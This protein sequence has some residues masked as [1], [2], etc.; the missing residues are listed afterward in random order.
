MKSATCKREGLD[1]L[2]DFAISARGS[3]LLLK[4]ISR[5][6]GTPVWRARK[7][8]EAREIIALAEMAPSGR[9]SIE[10]IDLSEELR[11]VCTLGVPTPRRG[12]DGQ[13]HVATG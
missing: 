3:A 9:L 5:N 13:V 11:V 8:A 1:A 10:Q 6:G 4:A 7:A 2:S 12:H